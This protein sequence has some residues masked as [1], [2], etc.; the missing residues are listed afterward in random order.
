M[1]Y[2]RKGHTTR[3]PK[4]FR[5]F[6]PPHDHCQW[7]NSNVINQIRNHNHLDTSAPWNHYDIHNHT[8]T[9]YST[10]LNHEIT[11]KTAST[12][13]TTDCWTTLQSVKSVTVLPLTSPE[14]STHKMTA[15]FFQS[16]R[17]WVGGLEAPWK[18]SI[19]AAD[20]PLPCFSSATNRFIITMFWRS[21]RQGFPPSSPA[22]TLLAVYFLPVAYAFVFCL[23]FSLPK[24]WA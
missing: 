4:G 13:I 18:Y 8:N 10:T 5:G 20:R 23:F 22:R 6:S 14:L 12:H 2:R 16:Y 7:P 17:R 15:A 19:P 3:I 9:V 21:A 24:R 1:A 11:I